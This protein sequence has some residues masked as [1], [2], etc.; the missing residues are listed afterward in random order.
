MI[1]N[2][3][4]LR[5]NIDILERYYWETCEK[6]PV[7]IKDIPELM[8]K[9][10]EKVKEQEQIKEQEEEFWEQEMKY[11]EYEWLASR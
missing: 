4:L 2:T 7:N 8:E 5:K 10:W 3:K 6:K 1:I 11:R 9:Y